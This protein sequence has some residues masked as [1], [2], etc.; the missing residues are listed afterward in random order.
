MLPPANFAR[1]LLFFLVGCL[2]FGLGLSADALSDFE[3]HQ[4]H[5]ADN[6]HKQHQT[7]QR[8]GQVDDKPL[9]SPGE[10][11]PAIGEGVG[12]LFPEGPLDGDRW[13]I[14]KA[15]KARVPEKYLF[16]LY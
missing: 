10:I 9:N 3:E 12:Q 1:L 13:I 15:R 2:L 8:P 4:H 6:D 5:A 11:V 14:E 16:L 7:G